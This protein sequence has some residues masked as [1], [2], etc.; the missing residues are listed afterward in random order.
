MLEGVVVASQ[1]PPASESAKA[2]SEQRE[3]FRE[4]DLS[5]L[6]TYLVR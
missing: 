3:M 1:A 5:D 4:N 6:S 2:A